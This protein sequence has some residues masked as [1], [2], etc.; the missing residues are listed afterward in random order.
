MRINPQL[1]LFGNWLFSNE[2]YRGCDGQW[3]F[4]MGEKIQSIF[5]SKKCHLD[6]Q[7]GA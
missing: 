2:L 4:R 1:V 7:V 3:N 5:Q 6:E